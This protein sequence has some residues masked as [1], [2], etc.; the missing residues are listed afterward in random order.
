MN[1]N[2]ILGAQQHRATTK[3]GYD[4]REYRSASPQHH[5]EESAH[6]IFKV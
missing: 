5:H 4:K 2:E 6:L 1:F 3:Q